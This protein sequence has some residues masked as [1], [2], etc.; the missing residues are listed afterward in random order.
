M[1]TTA[2]GGKE[3]ARRVLE[4]RASD[5]IPTPSKQKQAVRTIRL[6]LLHNKFSTLLASRD[7]VLDRYAQHLADYP[8][9][10]KGV[11]FQKILTSIERSLSAHE[12]TIRQFETSLKRLT[13]LDKTVETQVPE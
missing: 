11:A 2:T 5:F 6:N 7:K 3:S 13:D 12:R 8:G 1:I 10:R 9:D 4:Q